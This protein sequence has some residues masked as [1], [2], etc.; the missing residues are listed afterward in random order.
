M[1]LT[2]VYAMVYAFEQG[3]PVPVLSTHPSAGWLVRPVDQWPV[4]GRDVMTVG[5]PDIG[6]VLF[7]R[8][9]HARH[10]RSRR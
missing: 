1:T 9:F 10:L 2:D 6:E 7:T 3:A 8:S 5:D 4:F